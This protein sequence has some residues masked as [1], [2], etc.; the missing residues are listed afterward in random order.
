[1][2]DLRVFIYVQSY[3]YFFVC[4]ANLYFIICIGIYAES[5]MLSLISVLSKSAKKGSRREDHKRVKERN[6]KSKEGIPLSG[7][8]P[9]RGGVLII[10]NLCAEVGCSLLSRA[11]V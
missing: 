9:G 10:G 1:M 11:G 7:A 3:L 8:V 5:D 6:S 4:I 2:Q